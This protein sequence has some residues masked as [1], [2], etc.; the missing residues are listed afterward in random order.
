MYRLLCMVLCLLPSVAYAAPCT[1][2]WQAPQQ[3][4]DGNPPASPVNVTGPL[5][6]ELSISCPP[7]VNPPTHYQIWAGCDD[8][9]APVPTGYSNIY[10]N[11]NGT[12]NA[13]PL[14]IPGVADG[15]V[16]VN[17]TVSGGFVN[18]N[19]DLTKY[20]PNS[21]FEAINLSS[22]YDPSIGYYDAATPRDCPPNGNCDI[23]VTIGLPK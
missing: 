22:L 21:S 3:H 16:P 17:A 6:Y 15:G 7:G 12:C 19:F 8:S 14:A 23:A 11:S 9:G 4:L 13:S 18:F 2:I 10:M 20:F 1:L 5:N